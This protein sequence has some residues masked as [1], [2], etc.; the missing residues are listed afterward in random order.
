MMCWRSCAAF[1]AASNLMDARRPRRTNWLR[2]VVVLATLYG[3][4]AIGAFIVSDGMLFHPEYGSRAEPPGGFFLRDTDGTKLSVVY[5]PNPGARFTLWYFHGNGEDLGR[6]A[7]RMEALRQ[8]GYAVFAVDYPGYG[9]SD[10][11]PTEA[12]LYASTETGLR[13]LRE[14]LKITPTQLVLYGRSLGGG[15]AVELAT[16][17]PVAGLVLESAFTSAYRVMTRW[18]LLPGDKFE[19]LRK[20]PAVRCPVLVIHGRADGV[21]PFAHGEALFAAALGRKSHLWVDLAGHNDLLRWAGED[22]GRAV[23]EFARGL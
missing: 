2:L 21:I 11:T 12:S 17:E 14:Q 3:L 6:L 22:Y 9:M 5:L 10:G 23:R 1:S 19:N 15:P 4:V 7:P 13:Y 18:P 20:L 16:R 8:L